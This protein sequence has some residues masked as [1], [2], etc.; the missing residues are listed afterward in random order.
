MEFTAYT[1]TRKRLQKVVTYIDNHL[2]PVNDNVAEKIDPPPAKLVYQRD[3]EPAGFIVGDVDVYESKVV[4]AA[5]GMDAFILYS[6]ND[7][8][9]GV[10]EEVVAA[11][12][13]VHIVRLGTTI[14]AEFESAE[15]VAKTVE[16]EMLA[17]GNLDDLGRYRG[18][19]P[20]LGTKAE[21]GRLVPNENYERVCRVLQQF[22]DGRR[23][24]EN[25]SN[26]LGCTAKTVAKAAERKEL[27]DIE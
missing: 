12:T 4:P 11:G 23:T 17:K 3:G 25:A 10:V 20:P 16:N 27:Y 8:P 19:R 7:V 22:A 24:A 1:T 5:K 9:T 26:Q 6:L 15:R 18:G 14:R 2:I 21:G 13:D